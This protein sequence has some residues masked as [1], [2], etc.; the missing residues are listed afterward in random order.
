[1]KVDDIRE[2]IDL[3]VSSFASLSDESSIDETMMHK[4]EVFEKVNI[5]GT[6]DTERK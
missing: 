1:M 4:T 3:S 6:L 2:E 5:E